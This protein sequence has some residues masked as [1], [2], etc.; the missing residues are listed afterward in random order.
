MGKRSR[1]WVLLGHLLKASL[2]RAPCRLLLGQESTIRQFLLT[3]LV[4]AE[5]RFVWR[6]NLEAISQH[7]KDLMGFPEG[8]PSYQG[9][10]LFLG[11]AN[12]GYIR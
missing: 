3:N 2:L 12:S 5:D 11:G 8:Q 6:V 10:A 9:P 1:H 4:Y 7:L